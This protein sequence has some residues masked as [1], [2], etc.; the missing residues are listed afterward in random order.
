MNLFQFITLPLVGFLFVRNF[1]Q[2]FHGNQSRLIAL[3]GAAV[4]LSAG[5]AIYRPD[6]TIRIA[7]ILG[8]GRGADL[9]LYLL[10][11]SYLLAISYVY[12][13]FRKM[14]S[15]ITEI[16]RHLALREP[17]SGQPQA[18]GDPMNNEK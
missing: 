11:V 6:L 3:F 5:I 1:L 8:I 9:V 12:N 10:A 14:E 4:W 13:K 15:N 7:A 18:H 2:L 17:V 16:V